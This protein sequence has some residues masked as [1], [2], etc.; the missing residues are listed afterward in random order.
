MPKTEKVLEKLIF[1]HSRTRTH[2]RQLNGEY[3]YNHILNTNLV[4][5]CIQL[6][7]L[8]KSTIRVLDIG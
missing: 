7:N 2:Y 3:G 5:E 1:K 8:K 6:Y 4:D